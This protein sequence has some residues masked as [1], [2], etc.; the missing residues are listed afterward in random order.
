M[1]IRNT[2]Y[3]NKLW[4][5]PGRP[6]QGLI[7]LLKSTDMLNGVWVQVA[8]DDKVMRIS[9]EKLD[10]WMLEKHIPR[11]VFIGALEKQF[12]MVK[13]L[14]HLGGGT[15]LSGMQQYVYDISIIGALESMLDGL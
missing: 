6:T 9:A 7:Q 12:N 1:Q 8:R 3:T 14:G 15:G 10:T 4:T 11:K 5:L 2:I 13:R